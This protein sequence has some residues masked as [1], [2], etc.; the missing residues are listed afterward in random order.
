MRKWIEKIIACV[1]MS[2]FEIGIGEEMKIKKLIEYDCLYKRMGKWILK[3][4][5]MRLNVCNR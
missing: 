2:L 1:Q 4:Y 5:C 3:I